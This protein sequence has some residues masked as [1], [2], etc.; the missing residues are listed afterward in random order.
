MLNHVLQAPCLGLCAG[1][2]SRLGGG[3]PL[4]SCRCRF[5]Q[6]CRLLLRGAC[7]CLCRRCQ[8]T[9]C[10]RTGQAEGKQRAS[11]GEWG[12]E[13]TIVHA[14]TAW[15]CSHLLQ[16]LTTSEVSGS[17][18]RL[19]PTAALAKDRFKSL[20]KRGAIEPR[21]RI[22]QK[23]GRKK[24]RARA[25][26]WCTG[27]KCC[28]AACV[29]WRRGAIEPRRRILQEGEQAQEGAEGLWR[30]VP[31][32]G[33]SVAA[34]PSPAVRPLSR[35]RALLGSA[36]TRGANVALPRA[37]AVV[38]KQAGACAIDHGATWRRQYAGLS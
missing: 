7:W 37:A 2:R 13:Q 27:R 35:T 24:V 33:A 36:A 34:R 9:L 22:P 8:G 17:L 15:Q 12:C 31:S 5:V 14:T 30:K 32:A 28:M 4:S 6:G 1:G 11:T 26:L 29:L 19:R 16:V 10:A 38:A 18:R 25:P 21:K 20:Q 23:S 3:C